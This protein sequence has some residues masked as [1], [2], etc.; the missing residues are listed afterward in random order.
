MQKRIVTPSLR[1][2]KLVAVEPK[3]EGI[4]KPEITLHNL[5]G[6]KVDVTPDFHAAT[7]VHRIGRMVSED[8]PTIGNYVARLMEEF[9]SVNFCTIFR[10]PKNTRPCGLLEHRLTVSKCEQGFCI[11]ESTEGMEQHGIV[12]GALEKTFLERAPVIFDWDLGI[13]V[14]F[15]DLDM[16][17][18]RCDVYPLSK[19]DR[20]G[21]LTVMPFYY[22]D[23][24]HPSGMVVFEGDLTC[25]DSELK[26]FAKTYWSAKAVVDAA[27]QISFQLTHKFDAITVLTKFADFEVDFK[28]GIIN[29]MEKDIE[30]LH[31]ILIDADDFKRINDTY[32][33]NTG[34]RALR[35]IAE[36]INMSVRSS[37]LVARWGGEE[38]AVIV[39]NVSRE[40]AAQI[41]E[42]IRENVSQIEIGDIG[43]TC[44]IGVSDVGDIADKVAIEIAPAERQQVIYDQAFS[45]SDSRLKQA[46]RKGKNRVVSEGRASA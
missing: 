30:S 25:K 6:L 26:G 45:L 19:Q 40:R 31:L 23:P 13:K 17:S 20:S 41:A 15:G 7:T 43:V 11:D 42:R 32:G 34:N 10:V 1:P 2:K 9:N 18:D 27:A 38:F 3:A 12:R 28:K 8:F 29:L 4:I 16:Y 37:D 21:S 46:K 36:K 39:R 22:R 24:V 5:P 35:A 44:S 14:I 33:H